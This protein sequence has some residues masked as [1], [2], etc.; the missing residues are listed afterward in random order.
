MKTGTCEC[1]AAQYSIR[2]TAPVHV[3]ACHCLN[4]QTRS[5]SAFAEHAMIASAD[6]DAPAATL[7]HTRETNG[8]TFEEV[9]CATCFTRLFNRNS[10]MPDMIFLRA[11]TLSDS[12]ALKPFLHIW[13]S[14][15]QPW[16]ELPADSAAF[17]F[18]PT[19]E[20]FGAALAAIAT[21]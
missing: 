12:A 14:R 7:S 4:C 1:G 19:P 15:K 10:A 8:I 16:I 20:E 9:V 17:P 3:Y 2:G 13:T 11:G 6:F 18:S 21:S 5:G